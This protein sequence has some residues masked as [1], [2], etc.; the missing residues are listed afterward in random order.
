MR[1]EFDAPMIFAGQAFDLLDNA[2]LRPVSS[3][4]K[5]RDDCEAQFRPSFPLGQLDQTPR[6]MR[7][8]G[9]TFLNTRE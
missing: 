2:K 6:L 9:E 7:G 8:C 3:V 5:G 4:Q 1:V